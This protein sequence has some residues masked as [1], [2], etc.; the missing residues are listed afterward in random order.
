MLLKEKGDLDGAE[1]FYRRAI[2]AGDTKAMVALSILLHT[3]GRTDE[4]DAWMQRAR[5]AGWSEEG[6]WCPW[7]VGLP[8]LPLIS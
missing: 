3:Q 2:E 7:Q 1:Q 6:E 5:E 8:R 4:T